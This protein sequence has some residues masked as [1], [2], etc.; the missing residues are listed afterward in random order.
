MCVVE[1]K[2]RAKTWCKLTN[3][4]GETDEKMVDGAVEVSLSLTSDAPASPLSKSIS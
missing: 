4:L 1:V 3:T 2:V